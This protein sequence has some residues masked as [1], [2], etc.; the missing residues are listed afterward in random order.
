MVGAGG[1]AGWLGGVEGC[2]R[3]ESFFLFFSFS[4]SFGRRL[5]FPPSRSWRRQGSDTTSLSPALHGGVETEQFSRRKWEEKARRVGNAMSGG[6]AKEGWRRLRPAPLAR[7]PPLG[8][9]KELPLSRVPLF[10]Q[11]FL[12]TAPPG[13]S[14]PR[15]P[16]KWQQAACCGAPRQ[17][18]GRNER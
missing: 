1:G 3:V 2:S 7:S 8:G 12:G 4:V 15:N 6:A 17:E 18:R 13:L 16:E 10:P 14:P 9:E 11:L 5:R